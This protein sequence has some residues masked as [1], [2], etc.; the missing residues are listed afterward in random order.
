MGLIGFF[1]YDLLTAIFG[2]MTG[3]SRT[4]FALIGLSAVYTGIMGAQMMSMGM[5][6]GGKMMS[7][8]KMA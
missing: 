3:A 5:S 8:G 7:S 2:S 4:I 6:S 1:N